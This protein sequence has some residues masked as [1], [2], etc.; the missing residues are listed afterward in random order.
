M[1]SSPIPSLIFTTESYGPNGG[2]VVRVLLEE[3][4]TPVDA[5]V[6]ANDAMAIDAVR[7]LRRLE[8][9][10]PTDVAVS[11]FDDAPQARHCSPP[12]TTVRQPL[13]ELG[14]R[15]VETV[16]AAL[17][18]EDVPARQVLHA[19]LLVRQSCGCVRHPVRNRGLTDAPEAPVVAAGHRSSITPSTRPS[20]RP[21]PV[22]GLQ[23]ALR[24]DVTS[25]T[26]GF[27]P[28]L[29][30]VLEEA[31]AIRGEVGD[32]HDLLTRLRGRSSFASRT[33]PYNASVSKI[34]STPR[35]FS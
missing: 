35:G 27:L 2:E 32:A 14:Q 31:A 26:G 22:A 3:R 12:L 29:R 23:E 17:R 11:G 25:A 24:A 1:A 21:I 28:R 4:R 13:H 20:H 7:E 18:G 9:R 19:R 33:I 34:W 16:L 10:V 5:L 8:V 6:A 30:A 15:A